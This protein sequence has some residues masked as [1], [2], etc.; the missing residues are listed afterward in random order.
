M[1][2]A[3]YKMSQGT[4]KLP[5]TAEVSRV[6]DKCSC[7]LQEYLGFNA[8]TPE[9]YCECCASGASCS[10][11]SYDQKYTLYKELENHRI[12]RG[13]PYSHWEDLVVG[14]L[15]N[16]WIN[17]GEYN[18][19]WSKLDELVALQAKPKTYKITRSTTYG[20]VKVGAVHPAAKYKLD[21]LKKNYDPAVHRILS[22]AEYDQ[23]RQDILASP[24]VDDF[25]IGN[26]HK[27]MRIRFPS[28]PGANQST[29][30]QTP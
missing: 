12:L 26:A 5:D 30:G 11:L 29:P 1:A 23:L 19:L 14:A 28:Y 22:V 20:T 18:E 7:K 15:H 13:K 16:G 9:W 6:C 2:R 10:S 25:A 21:W 24:H 4:W 8:S 17:M 3:G 27:G